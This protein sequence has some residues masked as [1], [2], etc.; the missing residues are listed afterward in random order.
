MN[1]WPW[2]TAGAY[3]SRG[4]CETHVCI[5]RGLDCI[6][7]GLGCIGRGVGHVGCPQQ[8]MSRIT[9]YTVGAKSWVAIMIPTNELPVPACFQ[10]KPEIWKLQTWVR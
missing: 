10:L 7:R 5:G 1:G 8:E 4:T 9:T 3:C 6:G 2:K